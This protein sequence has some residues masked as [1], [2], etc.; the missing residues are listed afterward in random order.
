MT[1][2]VLII[3]S[4][5]APLPP[6][7]APLERDGLISAVRQDRLSAADID[8]AAGLVA[9]A[10]VDQLDLMERQESLERF[11]DA[12]G[13]M[14]FNGHVVRPFVQGLK[15]FV[16]LV[17]PHRGDFD[18]ARLAEHPVFSGIAARSLETNRGVAGFYGRGH[19][20]PPDGAVAI[21]GIG[22]G[23][24]PVDWEW[25]RPQ[26]GALFVHSGNDLWGVG[27]DPEVKRRIAARLVAWCRAWTPE[28]VP[29]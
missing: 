16:P 18:L 21:T 26:G 9:S 1:K 17:R 12:G 7:F 29:T 4:T 2:P 28:E 22:P 23:R 27:D 8:A 3:L 20:P 19:N 10:H 25:K 6:P 5:D 24:L 15:P 14:V 11:L 13:R